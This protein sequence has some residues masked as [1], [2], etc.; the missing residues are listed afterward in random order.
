MILETAIG[1]NYAR[2]SS[3]KTRILKPDSNYIVP[4]KMALDNNK[5]TPGNYQMFVRSNEEIVNN[6]F[7]NHNPWANPAQILF[8]GNGLLAGRMHTD[9]LCKN[10]TDVESFLRG[11]RANDLVNGPFSVKAE[12]QTPK[13]LDIFQKEPVIMPQPMI[14]SRENRPMY[15]S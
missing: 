2:S 6:S 13:S 15:L 9:V 1:N 14:V 8:P 5:N 10:D 4:P 7:Y 3:S 12:L 11:I